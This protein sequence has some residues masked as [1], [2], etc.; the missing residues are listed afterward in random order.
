MRTTTCW[1]WGGWAGSYAADNEP[2]GAELLGVTAAPLRPPEVPVLG[3]AQA[4]RAATTLSRRIETSPGLNAT[5]IT[6][7]A[8]E[9]GDA[10]RPGKRA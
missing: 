1:Y 8:S 6:P 7:R 2:Q 10:G 5:T 4:D 3:S 9:N